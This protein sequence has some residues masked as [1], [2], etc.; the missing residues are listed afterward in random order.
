MDLPAS[1]LIAAGLPVHVSDPGARAGADVVAGE[2][3]RARAVRLISVSDST[4]YSNIP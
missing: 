3:G 4:S 2:D 1:A